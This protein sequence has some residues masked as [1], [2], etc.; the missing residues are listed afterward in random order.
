MLASLL[1]SFGLL[2][3]PQAV[4]VGPLA[5]ANVRPTIG[6]QA[7]PNVILIIA[8]DFGVDFLGAYGEGSNPPCTPNIDA[9]ATESLLF[10]NA[11]TNPVCTPT[12]AAILT[13]RYGFRTG[14]GGVGG[15]VGLPLA[16]LC[17]PEMLRGYSTAAVG[18]WHLAGNL[19]NLHPNETGFGYYAG[20]LQGG[21]PDYFLWNKVSNGSSSQ[22][23]TYATTDTTDEAIA[24]ISS[25][26]EPWFCYVAYNSPHSPWHLPPDELCPGQGNCNQ[27]FCGTLPQGASNSRKGKAM[28][29]AMD[30]ELGRLLAVIDQVDPDAYVIFMGDNGTPPQ[31]TQSPFAPNHAKGTMYEGGVNVPMMV[32]GPT[33]TAGES[34]GLV[35]SVDM[36]ATL[37]ELCGSNATTAD[38]VSMVPYFSNS[39]LMLRSTVYSESFLP[40][41]SFPPIADHSRAIRDARYKL[42][43]IN[44]QADEFY[45]LDNDSFETAN[46]LPNLTAAEQASFDFLEAELVSLGVE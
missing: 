6:V 38:S 20:S 1:I 34:Q 32:R 19:G 40:N 2:V 17:L 7:K 25:M 33:V 13:G 44:G 9:L 3:A 10:R 8:D 14:M 31:L 42:I 27:V 30:T 35:S 29:E 21:L 37:S 5:P 23:T 46:L 16:E 11:W 45:D 41:G 43:R 15:N 18:K 24:A 39:S 26:P 22:V 28:T 36:F 4:S 12:R